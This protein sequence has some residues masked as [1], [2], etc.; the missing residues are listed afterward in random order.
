MQVLENHGVLQGQLR[1]A[2]AEN[3]VVPMT[4]ETHL[5]QALRDTLHRPGSFVRAELACNVGCAYEMG[6]EAAMALAIGVEYFH[7]ASLLFDDLP[8]MDDATHRRGALCVHQVHGEGMAILTALALINRAYGLVWKAAGSAERER[9]KQGLAY[10]EKYL[11]VGGLLD[12]QSRDLN[13]RGGKG[14]EGG[15]QIVAVGKTVSLVRLSLVLPAILGT[16]SARS[17]RLLDRLAVLWGLAYQAVDDLRDVLHG[18]QEAGK[19]TARD[20]LLD[21]PNLAVSVGCYETFEHVRRLLRLSD[22]IVGKLQHAEPQLR[23]LDEVGARFEREYAD[24]EKGMPMPVAADNPE[25][26]R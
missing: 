8:S 15:P 7:T 12:G 19:T 4:T 6:T 21:R 9:Q 14:W 3:L 17:V 20:T 22:R 26:P 11:G 25:A 16:A 13:Y 23:F 1:A 10:L 2:F 24:L 18:L 5:A